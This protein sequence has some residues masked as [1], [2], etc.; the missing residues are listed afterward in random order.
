MYA[1]KCGTISYGNRN[2]VIQNKTAP[3]TLKVFFS[4]ID[5]LLTQ[6]WSLQSC[7]MIIISMTFHNFILVVIRGNNTF[8]S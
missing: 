2:N 6:S 5:T 1:N 4:I 3:I 8:S 7:S